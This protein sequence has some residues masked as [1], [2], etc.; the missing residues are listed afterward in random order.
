MYE[1]EIERYGGE[2]GIEL[3]EQ[4]F[5][6]DSEAVVRFLQSLDDD[7]RGDTRWRIT[8]LGM[9]RMLQDLGLTLKEK[10]DL[11]RRLRQHEDLSPRSSPKFRAEAA[12]LVRLLNADDISQ[13]WATAHAILDERSQRNALAARLL[14]QRDQHGQLTASIPDI[15]ASLLHMHANRMLRS[16]LQMQERVLYDYLFRI[17][18]SQAQRD[19]Q[20]EDVEIQRKPAVAT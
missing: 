2:A 20:S 3:C 13:E 5:H 12:A 18:E 8:L 4:L 7:S 17:Y 16:S 14:R 11:L 9:D 1:R 10:R 6:H 19:M 15:A